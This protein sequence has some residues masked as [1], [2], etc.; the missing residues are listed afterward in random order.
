MLKLLDRETAIARATDG[1]LAVLMVQLRRVDRLQAL[2]RG[3]APATTMAL[4]LERLAK[5]LRNEDR[6][7]AINDEE[8]CLI[9]PRLAHPS[10]AVLAAVKV[11]RL[12]DRPIA[13]EGGSAVLR[14]CIGV[15]T[16]P[17][18]GFDPAAL[19]MAADVARHIAATREEGYHVFQGDEVVEA[20]VYHGLDI[21][22]ERALRANE[23]EINYQPQVELATRRPVGVEALLR[24][25]HLQAGDIPPTTIVGIA[26]RTGLISALTHWILNAALRQAQQW[27]AAGIAPRLALNLT[28]SMLGDRE[29]PAVIDQ[30]VKTWGL[31]P[32]RIVFEVA[33]ST[34]L[35]EA[36]R[37]MAIL[38][39]LKGLG[40]QVSLDDF[41]SG[42]TSLVNL[43]RLPIDEIKID[44]PF[45]NGLLEDAGDQ[46]IVRSAIALGHNFGF[47]VVA[48]GI[49]R[50]EVRDALAGL[51]CDVGQG[52]VFAKPMLEVAFRDWW[53]A[54]AG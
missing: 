10:Q 19:L 53:R 48:E 2:L 1:R 13:H 25:R 41:G 15:A 5:A 40:A 21:D 44:R 7:A 8:I 20:E 34:A 45:V 50:P 31:D 4:V 30:G 47:R 22:L 43:K 29:L 37:S 12:L 17:E 9:L 11:L 36:E 49:E 14:P 46:A 38:T 51:G 54:N 16:L 35:V 28:A 27:Q 3:P 6:M 26:E 42:F 24:W 23:L 33:E 52:Y 32:T 39:R 18:H